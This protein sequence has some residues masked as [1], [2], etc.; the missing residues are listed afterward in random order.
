MLVGCENGEENP[1][2]PNEESSGITIEDYT[3]EVEDTSD[4]KHSFSI[5]YTDKYMVKAGATDYKVIVPSAMSE[6][7][8]FARDEL[9]GFFK[10]ATGITLAC[11]SDTGLTHSATNKYIS[12]GNT[13]LLATSGV[14]VDKSALG[15]DGVRIKTVDETV[16][17][18]GGGD[19]GVLNAVYTFLERVFDFEFFYTDSYSIDKNV[20]EVKLRNFDV[21]DVPDIAYRIPNMGFLWNNQIITKRMKFSDS[22]FS[23]KM[24]V[25]NPV[26][27]EH[28]QATD[29]KKCKEFGGCE[30]ASSGNNTHNS[31]VYLPPEYYNDK[32]RN[33]ASYHPEWFAT[34]DT[35]Q[36]CYTAGIKEEDRQTGD[37]YDLMVNTI[38]EV[39]KYNLEINKDDEFI[40]L[41]LEDRAGWCSCEACKASL[42]KYGSNSASVV[43]MCNTLNQKLQSWLKENDETRTVHISILAYFEMVTAPV[44]NGEATVKADPEIAVTYAPIEASFVDPLS[45]EINASFYDQ[46]QNWL[47]VCDNMMMWSYSTNYHDFFMPVNTINSQQENYKLYKDAG[48]VWIFNQAQHNQPSGGTSWL[49]FKTYL[50]SKWG[51]NVNYD[52][53]FL[54]SRFFKHHFGDAW[55]EMLD[56]FNCYRDHWA[57]QE[58]KGMTSTKTAYAGVYKDSQF[59]PKQTLL[60]WMD[61]FDGAIEQIEGL[62]TT[63]LAKYNSLYKHIV[64]ERLYVNYML[65]IFYADTSLAQEAT[66]WKQQFKTD[67]RLTG[68]TIASETAEIDEVLKGWGVL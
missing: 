62:K 23:G 49:T 56:I 32:D 7:L 52:Y 22:F 20:E 58:S 35:E 24:W 47:K 13:T 39:M 4:P 51:W 53:D 18:T 37:S 48:T 9:I 36:L 11:V 27:A 55:K 43:I 61:K 44:V 64:M 29:D 17:L 25:K 54:A 28:C 59:W 46:M 2:P 66:A 3:A 10:E 16:F 34:G 38:F 1:T 63:D 14:S 67:V 60:Q 12:L 6:R 15:S 57:I 30:K 26:P 21:T 68:L 8:E 42:L 31:F 33:P 40:F 45:A 50:D 19:D 65:V 41:G 5:K